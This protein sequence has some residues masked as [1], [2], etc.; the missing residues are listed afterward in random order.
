[1]D[2][3]YSLG[4]AG[5][6][7]LILGVFSPLISAPFIGTINYF[8]NGTGDGVFILI[9]AVVALLATFQREFKYHGY[10]GILSLGLIGFTFVSVESRLSEAQD[11]MRSDLAGNPFRG[12]AEAMTGA[13]QM[14]WGWAV[15][16]VGAVLLI[17]AGMKPKAAPPNSPPAHHTT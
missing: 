8:Q 12:L 5:S 4:L 15:L 17:A 1:M 2:N 16:A 9:L 14:Q 13:I 10:L 7:S 11:K 6:L 3:R